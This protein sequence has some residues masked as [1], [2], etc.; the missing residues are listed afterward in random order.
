MAIRMLSHLFSIGIVG[1]LLFA[2]TLNAE[3]PLHK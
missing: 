1:A 3:P 2:A